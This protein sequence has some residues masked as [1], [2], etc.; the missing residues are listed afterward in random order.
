MVIS[1]DL[2]VHFSSGLGQN[3]G[4]VADILCRR[5]QDVRDGMNDGMN[6]GGQKPERAAP[7]GA[8]RSRGSVRLD[9]C[10]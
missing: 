9:Q 10:A 8:A 4:N 7:E 3:S 6:T 1:L 5:R 2:P